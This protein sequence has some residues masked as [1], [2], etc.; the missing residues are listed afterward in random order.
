MAGSRSIVSEHRFRQ[1]PSRAPGPTDGISSTAGTAAISQWDSTWGNSPKL[2]LSQHGGKHTTPVSVD[3]SA[4]HP[5]LLNSSKR[6]TSR[7]RSGLSA[8]RHGSLISCPAIVSRPARGTGRRAVREAARNTPPIYPR[9]STPWPRRRSARPSCSRRRCRAPG[10][11][12]MPPISAAG[13]GKTRHLVD[14]SGRAS[15][16]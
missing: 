8:P 1:R 11:G 16:R 2:A 7:S 3:E 6:K 13:A 9:V 5:A 4:A 12:A 14:Q 10:P 15:R